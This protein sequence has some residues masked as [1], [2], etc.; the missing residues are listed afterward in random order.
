MS[1]GNMEV[2][3]RST[4]A[5]NRGDIDGTLESWAP[6]AVLDWSRSRGPDAG[7]FRGRTAIREFMQEFL[8]TFETARLD[9]VDPVEVQGGVLVVENVAHL[10]GRDGIQVEARS[11]WL[12]TLRD[13]KQTSLTLYQTRAEALEAA[14]D[15]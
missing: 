7:V 3:R 9:L 4:E 6:D 12:V 11:A 10:R 14:A 15:D 13:G 8:A 2:V 5:Y 1:E